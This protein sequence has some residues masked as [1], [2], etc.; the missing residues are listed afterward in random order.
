[1][2]IDALQQKTFTA[3]QFAARIRNL[4]TDL[5]TIATDLVASLVS[6][7]QLA[8]E[9]A[10]EGINPELIDRLERLGRKQLSSRLVFATSPGGVKLGQCLLSEQDLLLDAGVEVLTASNDTRVIPVHELTPAQAR[11]VFARG[12]VRSLAEQRS[13]REEAAA[14]KVPTDNSVNFSVHKDFV[15]TSQPGRWSKRLILQWLTEMS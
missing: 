5:L 11:Q 13:W 7:P 12:K 8:R 3:T 9:I 6:R 2:T 1:M 10:A 15:V 4:S 14:K